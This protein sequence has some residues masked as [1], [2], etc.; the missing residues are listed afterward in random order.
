MEKAHTRIFSSLRIRNYR[1]YAAGQVISNTGTWMQRV[2]QDWLVLELTHG[3]GTALGIATG[4]QFLPLLL[5]SLWGGAIA[6]RYAKRRILMTTQAIMGGLALILGVL[7]LTGVVQIW[8]VYVL[9][10]ALGLVTVVDNPTRQTFAV[11][12][13]GR[14]DMP[15]AIALNSAIFNLAR[16][17]GPAVAGVVIS[18]AGTPIAFVVNAGSYAAVLAGLALMR[19]AE[20][21]PVEPAP[22]AKGQV[23]EGLAYVKARPSLWMPMLLI[24]FVATFGMNFQVTTALMSRE[25]FHTGAG[26][27]GVA[28]ATFAAGALAGALLAARRRRPSAGL[29]VVTAAIFG[30]LEAVTAL[31]PGYWPFLVLLVPTGL[32]LLTFTTAANSATQLGTAPE[33]RGRVMGLY[34]LVFLGGTPLGAPLVG[35]VAEQFGPRV[36]LL[37]GGGVSAL[38]AV[39]VA[40][41]LSRSHRVRMRD[42]LRPKMLARLV[43]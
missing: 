17:L 33:M 28:S 3:S 9:A 8:H 35:W 15:N 13:V 7:S 25:V 42:Y 11:E 21:R 2:A 32:A 19:P 5:F 12:M 24:F 16:I 41:M 4:L 38:A 10:F 18:L 29:L 34:L 30:V 20:L 37:A 1:L 14:A 39:A 6:D 23:R 36:S 31:M 27:F 43:A 22:R 26:A 40:A